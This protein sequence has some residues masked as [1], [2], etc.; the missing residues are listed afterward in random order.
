MHYIVMDLEFNWPYDGQFSERNN[1][2]LRN[3]IIE[4]GAVKM[5]DSLKGAGTF[6]TYVHPLAYCKVNK[7]VN[8]LTGISTQMLWYR[9]TFPITMHRFL[10]WCGDECIFVT[11]SNTDMQ[12]LKENMIYHGMRIDK[13]PECYDIQK[14]FDDQ[15]SKIGQA[16][17][18][19]KAINLMEINFKGKRLHDALFDAVGTAEIFRR[20]DLNKS[21]ESYMVS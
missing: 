16:I 15:V 19:S 4:I 6:C 11:W 17:A 8:K 5:T 2:K 10:S 21:F 14:M 9:N 18:L 3:E 13:L 12:A 1:V 7:K 20:L